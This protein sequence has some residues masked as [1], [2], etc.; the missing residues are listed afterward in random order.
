MPKGC[1]KGKHI[2]N[3]NF[4]NGPLKKSYNKDGKGEK[5]GGCCAAKKEEKKLVIPA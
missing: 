1:Q 2:L 3:F 5:R 4:S